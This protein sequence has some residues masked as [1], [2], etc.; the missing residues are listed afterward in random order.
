MEN[1]VSG[2]TNVDTMLTLW[3]AK[4]ESYCS[5][6]LIRPGPA[7]PAIKDRHLGNRERPDVEE[8]HV[9]LL[10]LRVRGL[11]VD[12]D[13]VSEPLP[14]QHHLRGPRVVRRRDLLEP[15]VRQQLASLAGAAKRGVPVDKDATRERERSMGGWATRI[16]GRKVVK[17]L[18]HG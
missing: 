3:G 9:F 17:W 16:K 2:V 18:A 14:R 6:A 11:G 12:D 10:V 1:T 5:G 4:G 7:L 15:G 13:L 8:V